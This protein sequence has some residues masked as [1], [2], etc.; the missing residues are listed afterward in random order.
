MHKNEQVI[1]LSDVILL[2]LNKTK[3]FLE[4]ITSAIK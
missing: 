1:V 4:T 3:N 2:A